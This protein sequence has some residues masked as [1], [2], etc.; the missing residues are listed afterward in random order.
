MGK[1]TKHSA[2]PHASSC[3]RIVLEQYAVRA[4]SHL[5]DFPHIM[6]RCMPACSGRHENNGTY[7]ASYNLAQWK[8]RK[9]SDLLRSRS[10]DWIVF[11]P[12][13][14]SWISYFP[15]LALIEIFH[16]LPLHHV[17]NPK[18]MPTQRFVWLDVSYIPHGQRTWA[19]HENVA[20]KQVHR[21]DEAGLND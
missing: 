18:P 17:V 10:G 5:P 2:T 15:S 3:F 7:H 9:A 1:A 4:W 6:S 12:A 16:N 14:V 19:Q 20:G 13:I 11:I 21:N 8:A